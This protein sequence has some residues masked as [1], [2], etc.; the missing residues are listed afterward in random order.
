MIDQLEAK[1]SEHIERERTNDPEGSDR[2]ERMGGDDRT[3]P[4]RI[5]HDLG[6]ARHQ[7]AVARRNVRHDCVGSQKF[8][9]D[10]WRTTSGY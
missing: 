6:A 1:Q 3:F 4:G 5:L 7:H 8:A 9:M 10:P 2:N